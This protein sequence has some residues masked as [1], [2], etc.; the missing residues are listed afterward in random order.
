MRLLG[1]ACLL[2]AIA[3]AWVATW[4]DSSVV[5]RLAAATASVQQVDARQRAQADAVMTRALASALF[6]RDYGV[7]QELLTHYAEVGY[8]IA[9]AVTNA[10]NQVV[11][12][13]GATPGVAIGNVLPEGAAQNGRRVTLLL[14]SEEF[15]QL[16]VL[17]EPRNIEIATLTA[18]IA[19][20]KNAIRALMLISVALAA[21][22]IF[23]FGWQWRGARI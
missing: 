23:Q 2:L 9:A 12:S 8:F 6:A 3:C 10:A 16:V 21:G 5:P 20:L 14:R 19:A 11:A 7:A 13:V 18:R 15:G 17:G 4:L 1:L 22:L